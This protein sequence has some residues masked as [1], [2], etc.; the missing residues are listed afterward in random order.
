MHYQHKIT[1]YKQSIA[2]V[3][4]TVLIHLSLEHEYSLIDPIE[5]FELAVRFLQ[6]ILLQKKQSVLWYER[7]GDSL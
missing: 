6:R 1:T 4:S 7:G 5:G 2:V 3:L